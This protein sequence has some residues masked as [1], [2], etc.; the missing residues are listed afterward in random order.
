MR[1]KNDRNKCTL[2]KYDLLKKWDWIAVTY[3]FITQIYNGKWAVS[4]TQ[5]EKKFHGGKFTCDFDKR[6]I[7]ATKLGIKHK[8]TLF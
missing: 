3:F 8:G 7:E 6:G 4:S 5:T 1:H 2:K